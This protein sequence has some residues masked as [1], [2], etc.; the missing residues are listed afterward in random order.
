MEA[1][2]WPG[3]AIINGITAPGCLIASDYTANR[4]RNL[5][6]LVAKGNAL[7]HHW[8]WDGRPGDQWPGG[9]AATPVLGGGCFLQS[10]FE[11]GPHANYELTVPARIQD[12]GMAAIN[13]AVHYF[14][15]PDVGGGPWQRG[16]K[17]KLSRP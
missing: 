15:V 16:Q 14:R 5:E 9:Q 8:T 1:G 17:R 10:D 6:V 7:W 12:P 3:I 2:Q 13:E 4:I 11:G